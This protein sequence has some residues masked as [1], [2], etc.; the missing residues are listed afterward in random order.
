MK[1][2]NRLWRHASELYMKNAG[3]QDWPCLFGC[4]VPLASMSFLQIHAL[5]NGYL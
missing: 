4:N 3:N 5:P 1:C 2:A